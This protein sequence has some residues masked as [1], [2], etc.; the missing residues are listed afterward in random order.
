MSSL[1]S[2]AFQ[3][4]LT[5]LKRIKR[6]SNVLANRY[7]EQAQK[8]SSHLTAASNVNF[9]QDSLV[10]SGYK[11]PPIPIMFPRAQQLPRLSVILPTPSHSLPVYS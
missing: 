8:N 6:E 1:P 3:C 5:P 10:K 11:P 4:S 2:M 9:P 7:G